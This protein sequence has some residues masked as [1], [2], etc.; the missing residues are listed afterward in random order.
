MTSAIEVVTALAIIETSSSSVVQRGIRYSPRN[1][2]SPTTTIVNSN[3][4]PW[5]NENGCCD[6]GRTVPPIC[7][8]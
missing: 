2:N 6:D 8:L 3:S 5:K 1:W 4:L 7:M